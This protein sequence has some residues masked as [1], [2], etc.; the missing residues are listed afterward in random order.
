MKTKLA[1]LKPKSL[2]SL[3]DIQGKVMAPIFMYML[4]VPGGVCLLL[5]VFFFRGK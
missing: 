3:T 1:S 5:W 2:P 4:G